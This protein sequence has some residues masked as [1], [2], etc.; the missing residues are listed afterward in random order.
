MYLRAL[1]ILLLCLFSIPG[2]AIA[3]VQRKA[4]ITAASPNNERRILEQDCR[5]IIV[6]INSYFSN[7][8]AYNSSARILSIKKYITEYLTSKGT[9]TA[10][11]IL[12][13]YEQRGWSNI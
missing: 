13:E 7:M 11:A 4:H 6:E 9:S 1:P 8:G 12:A 2:Y 3:N 5:S 10:M